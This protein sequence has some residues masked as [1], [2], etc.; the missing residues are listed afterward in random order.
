MSLSY[1]SVLTDRGAL[2]STAVDPEAEAV[3]SPGMGI[4]SGDMVRVFSTAGTSGGPQFFQS[5]PETCKMHKTMFKPQ[6]F[7]ITVKAFPAFP[8]SQKINLFRPE[9]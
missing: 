4:G 7:P 8:Y 5:K 2:S 3:R 9:S 6:I 1:I